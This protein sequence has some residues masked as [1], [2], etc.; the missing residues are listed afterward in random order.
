MTT[1]LFRPFMYIK[2]LLEELH[3]KANEEKVQKHAKNISWMFSIKII[4]MVISFFSTAYIARHLGP[5]NYGELSY[6]I[7]FVRIFLF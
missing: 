6:A 2:A 5:A 1:K 4:S 3:L 7:S